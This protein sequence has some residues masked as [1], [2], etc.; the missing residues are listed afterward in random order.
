[1]TDGAL[2]ALID[3]R[4]LLRFVS[5]GVAGAAV[6]L[7]VSAGLV[8]VTQVP[9]EVAKFVGAELAIVVM[10]VINDR[11]TFREAG[12]SG[13]WHGLRRLVKSNGVRG[14][15]L[16]VQLVVVFV[17]VRTGVEVWVGGTDLWPA[18]V[19]PIAIGCGFVVNYT[20]ETLFT[21]RAQR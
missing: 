11:W 3:R 2:D 9:P 6:D 19:M 10:F 15:G 5:V 8:L 1:M 7:P 20:G 21:W 17:L 13:W 12:R 14:G 16:L 18:I 4:R